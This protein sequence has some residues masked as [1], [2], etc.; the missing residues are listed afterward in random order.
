M[1]INH[2][3]APDRYEVTYRNLPCGRMRARTVGRPVRGVPEVVLVQGMAVSDYL[4]PALARLGD[5][6]R[7][8]LVDLPGLAGSGDPPHELNVPQYGE[9]VAAWLDAAALGRV[10]VAGH[11]SGA[12]VAAHATALRPRDGTFTGVDV[13]AYPRDLACFVRMHR[14]LA[15]VRP[16]HPMPGPLDP[17]TAFA[18]LDRHPNVRLAPQ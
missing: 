15:R 2:P 7:A 4:M 1:D 6:T 18:F 11:S 12:Q 8:H 14:D 3:E 17:E 13:R 5:W 10:F 16:V 9:A